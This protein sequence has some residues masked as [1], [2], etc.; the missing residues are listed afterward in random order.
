MRSWQQ[1]RTGE[2][3]VTSVEY[4]VLLALIVIVMIAGVKT[5]TSQQSAMWE[6]NHEQLEAVGFGG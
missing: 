5:L 6:H 3:G 2:D 1:L 4:A